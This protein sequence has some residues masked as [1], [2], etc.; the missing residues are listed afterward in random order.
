MVLSY[1]LRLGPA[2]DQNVHGLTKRKRKCRNT[3]S[4]KSKVR[5]E[6]RLD[7]QKRK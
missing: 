2:K 3:Q 7:G 5:L 4:R 1:K 6:K